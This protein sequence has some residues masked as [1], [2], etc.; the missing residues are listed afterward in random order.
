MRACTRGAP[1]ARRMIS[2]PDRPLPT[3][4]LA[5]PSKTSRMPGTAKAPKDWPA[6][7]VSSK[8]DAAAGGRVM[9]ALQRQVRRRGA[10]RRRGLSFA[11]CAADRKGL[12]SRAAARAGSTH[13]SS[14]GVIRLRAHIALPCPCA[15][16]STGAASM[17]RQVERAD[18]SASAPADRCGRWQLRAKAG[19][20]RRA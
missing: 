2:P 6:T 3:K 15:P 12:P 14:I 18:R 8:V 20:D 9:Q 4:S 19:P 11:I 5:R 17:R 13:A 1:S 10:R 7:P 16:P